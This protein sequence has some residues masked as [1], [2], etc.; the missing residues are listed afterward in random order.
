MITGDDRP[1]QVC[2]ILGRKT[3][4]DQ[5]RRCVPLLIPPERTLVVV[6]RTHEPFY[7]LLV[8]D[9]APAPS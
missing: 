5:T 3:L 1:K 7:A 4:L 2:S 9:M 6:T 8:A